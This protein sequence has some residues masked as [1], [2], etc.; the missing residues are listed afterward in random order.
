MDQT[1]KLLSSVKRRNLPRIPNKCIE[2]HRLR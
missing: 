1:P 2:K